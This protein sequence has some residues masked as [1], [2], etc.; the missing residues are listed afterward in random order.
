MNRLAGDQRMKSK[1]VLGN[2]AVM[3]TSLVFATMVCEVGARLVLNPADYLSVTTLR[4]PVLGMTIAPNSPGFDKWGF[5]NPAVPERVDILA[6]GDS[7]TFGNT[8]KMDEA[9]PSVVQRQTGLTVYNMGLGGYGPNQYYQ[10]LTTRGLSLHP[11]RVVLGLYMGDDFENA[12][13]TTYGLDHWAPLRTGRWGKVEA[14]IWGDSEPPGRFKVFR[15]WLSRNSMV[16][17]LVIHGQGLRALKGSVQTKMATSDPSVTTFDSADGTIHEAF[18]PIRIANGLDQERAEVK[19]GMR[20]TFHFLDEMNLAC[21]KSG[22]VFSVVVIPT[23][24]TVFAK[25]LQSEPQLNLK[26][27]VNAVITNEQIATTVL[28]KFLVDERI[29]YTLALPAL[30]ERVTEQLYYRG[31]AD[32]HPGPNGYRVIGETV[33]RFLR[34]TDTGEHRG[35]H[36]PT[37]G[38]Q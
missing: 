38:S 8:A 35:E 1:Q 3:L 30:R 26:D 14:D 21:Q 18:R 5:R 7:H 4:D 29:P 22:C 11:K 17:R 33:S 28:E 36:P 25:Y 10:L 2:V 13:S 12:F 34:Q 15:N 19:E 24:E 27:V 20:L 16:Y 9:W 6:L 37:A 32:M 23:K 31:P